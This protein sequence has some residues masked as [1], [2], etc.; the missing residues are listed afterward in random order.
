MGSLQKSSADPPITGT[1]AV[2]PD[3]TLP[4]SKCFDGDWSV[5]FPY[6]RGMCCGMTATTEDTINMAAKT[7]SLV[8]IVSKP[9][10]G[11]LSLIFGD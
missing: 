1:T 8:D 11:T 6:G 3:N 9:E 10:F 7:N 4:S 5:N 2:G